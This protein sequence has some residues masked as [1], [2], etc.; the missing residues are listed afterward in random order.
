M[1]ER[2]PVDTLAAYGKAFLRL[3]SL[4]GKT[5]IVTGG[6]RGIGKAISLALALAGA[7]VVVAARS[8]EDSPSLPGTIYKTAEEIKD[9]GGNAMPIR[10]DVTEVGDIHKMVEQTVNSYG[11]I[12]ILV[13]NAGVLH[14]ASFLETKIDD[15]NN[16]W[17]VNVRG[18]FLCAQAVLPL[19]I[20]R[21]SGSIINISSGLAESTHPGNIAYS[22]SKAALNRMM[23]NLAEE[24]AKHNIAVNLLYPGMVRSEGMITSVSQEMAERLPPPSI[25]GPPVVWLAAQDAAGFTG[26][27]VQ[28]NTFGSDWP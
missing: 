9:L 13:N 7:N 23:L 8:E 17:Q 15:F 10:C 19:V 18:A 27:I 26:Q 2:H 12:D 11:A 25:V 4:A 24:V 20:P 6:S 1:V 5:A 28:A 22:A 14:S 16:I 3:Y 21:K